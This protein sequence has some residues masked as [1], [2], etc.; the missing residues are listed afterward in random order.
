MT[1]EHFIGTA[2]YLETMNRWS[3]ALALLVLCMACAD[4]PPGGTLRGVRVSDARVNAVVRGVCALFACDG[5][6][7]SDDG[8]DF[9]NYLRGEV[10]LQ[11]RREGD[12][13]CIDARLDYLACFAQLSCAESEEHGGVPNFDHPACG[14]LAET[15][16]NLCPVEE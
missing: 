1:I 14:A 13:A 10:G 15:R 12:E 4:G 7:C 16:D 9:P 3:N 2:R 8:G 5:S 11:D 6:R